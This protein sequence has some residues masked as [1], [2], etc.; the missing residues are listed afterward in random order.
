MRGVVHGLGT[1][2]PDAREH[3][4]TECGGGERG[5]QCFETDRRNGGDGLTYGTSP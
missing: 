5:P 2:E 1:D 3:E 4:Q